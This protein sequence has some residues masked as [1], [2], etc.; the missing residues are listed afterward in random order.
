[1]S[2]PKTAE[3]V[4][5]AGL[6]R[7]TIP[8]E[9]PIPNR[10]V[11][12]SVSHVR[13][14]PS[15]RTYSYQA[16]PR[17]SPSPALFPSLLALPTE[18]TATAIN[19][20]AGL[21]RRISTPAMFRRQTKDVHEAEV[22]EGQ[23]KAKE[24]DS[25]ARATSTSLVVPKTLDGNVIPLY[26][27][28]TF[29][30]SSAPPH[31]PPFKNHMTLPLKSE[32]WSGVYVTPASPAQVDLRQPTSST[33]V[34]KKACHLGESSVLRLAKWVRPRP[35]Q[36]LL[37]QRRGSEDSEK[38]LDASDQSSLDS[39][40][41]R[42][43]EDSIRQNEQYWGDGSSRKSSDHD[44]GYFSL[45]PT[46]PDDK[47][48]TRIPE[49]AAAFQ[50]AEGSLPT[51]ALSSRSLSRSGSKRDVLQGLRGLRDSKPGDGWSGSE[52]GVWSRSGTGRTGEVMREM[53]WTVGML[54][55]LL[56]VTAAMALWLIKGLPM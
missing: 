12:R 47:G 24:V 20:R 4:Y 18:E 9:T 25:R 41:T 5:E 32:N 56:F 53:G 49:L 31:A 7:L 34:L 23:K 35:R 46:P 29:A 38:G 39:G 3:M 15:S 55:G 54:T 26:P 1:M 51:P 44:S 21:K 37:A 22:E 17:A 48:E 45:P 19:K 30:P 2:G 52:Y 10:N 13:P 40:V 16:P 43:S 36:H 6:S 27:A 14:P 50:M 28:N 33:S 42:T 11:S 8:I